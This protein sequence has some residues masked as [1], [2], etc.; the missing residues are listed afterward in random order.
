VR[1]NLNYVRRKDLEKENYH[2][3][4]I[5]VNYNVN[6]RLI[7]VYKSFRPPVLASPT[8]FF[9][10]QLSFIGNALTS[11]CYVM[12]DLNLDAILPKKII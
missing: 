2:I 11:N 5:D 1:K 4:I 12:G 10:T 7:C 9:E 8:A 3:F 6:F